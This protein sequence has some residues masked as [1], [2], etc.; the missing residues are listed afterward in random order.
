MPMSTMAGAFDVAAMRAM[1]ERQLRHLVTPGTFNAKYSRG[2]LVDAEYTV[3]ALQIMHG[4][5]HPEL[6]LT[7][8]RAAVTAL[9]AAGILSPE[10][11]V[12]LSSGHLFLQNLINA[13]RMVRGNSRDLTIPPE[14]SDEFDFLARRL[15]YADDP[16][17]LQADLTRH[18][19]WVRRLN[20]S[21]LPQAT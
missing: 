17:R 11:A 10:H 15:G 12:E 1:R 8:T 7:N 14:A 3:Q 4:H 16:A 18:T 21:L 2:G 9:A 13:L 5:S 19:S 6:R 20:S